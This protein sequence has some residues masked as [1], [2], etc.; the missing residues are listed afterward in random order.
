MNRIRH[1][2]RI[3]AALAAVGCVA[4]ACHRGADPGFRP[5]PGARAEFLIGLGDLDDRDP[6][7][8]VRVRS[9]QPGIIE[10]FSFEQEAAEKQRREAIEDGKK[11]IAGDPSTGKPAL[12][13]APYRDG[14]PYE[15][16]APDGRC[17]GIWWKRFTPHVIKERMSR[18]GRTATVEAIR[19]A[20]HAAA[21]GQAYDAGCIQGGWLYEDPDFVP[22][23]GAK[24]I[25]LVQES[26]DGSG[27]RAVT[28]KIQARRHREFESLTGRH[29]NHPLCLVVQ[30]EIWMNPVIMESLR[31]T[32]Q[33]F[34]PGGGFSKEEQD[35]LLAGFR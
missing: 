20:I 11:P 15:L 10:E 25:D 2:M 22:A 35:A 29:V 30:D 27:G 5:G 8:T 12:R 33:V 31:D 17:L 19:D 23:F 34:K 6:R 9:A 1:E 24:D 13:P 14:Q 26:Q 32:L 28:L 4:G 16:K 7:R 18:M 3:L 21:R